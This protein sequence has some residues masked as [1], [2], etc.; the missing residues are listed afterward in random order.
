MQIA[1]LME[2]LEEATEH[3]DERRTK[4]ADADVI[5]KI[6]YAKQMVLNANSP[7]LPTVGLK[8]AKALIECDVELTEREVTRAMADSAKM[9][10]VSL[11]ARLSSA[12][13]LLRSIVNQT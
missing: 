1:D 10:M 5:Y 11:Q 6:K 9:A 2:A 8:E 13:T 4:E 7:S 12:Q 3:Y